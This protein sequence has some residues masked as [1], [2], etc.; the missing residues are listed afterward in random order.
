[1]VSLKNKKENCSSK[2]LI[3]I[4]IKFLK[5]QNQKINPKKFLRKIKIKNFKKAYEKKNKKKKK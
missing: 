2:K 4:M 3:K 1:M 5:F